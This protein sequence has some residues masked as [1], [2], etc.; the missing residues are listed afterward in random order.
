MKQ[1]GEQVVATNRQARHRYALGDA[2]ECGIVLVGSEVK[3]LRESK[4][5]LTEAWASI[6][7]NEVWLHGLHIAPYS[8]A[9]SHT[10]H[11]PVRDRKLLMHRHQIERLRLK[12][13]VER[14]TLVPT[15]LYF[16]DGRVKV[17]IALGKG[18]NV[19]DKR[20]TIMERDTAREAAREMSRARRQPR[21]D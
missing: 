17:E 3:S 20:Q 11:V 1:T 19:G 7:G 9:Q 13:Q 2:F 16:K 4:V 18:K 21:D 15:K 12:L 8:H 14:L 5:Q 10:G 6:E